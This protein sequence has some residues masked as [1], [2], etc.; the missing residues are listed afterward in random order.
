MSN[1]V[2]ALPV[3]KRDATAEERFMEL[4]QMAREDP[5]RF[6]KVIIGYLGVK[7]CK[8]GVSNYVTTGCNAL[9]AL[10]LA[11]LTLRNVEDWN[12]E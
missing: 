7:D 6:E 9:D 5:G 3:W 8:P 2:T 11:T 1:N 4:A 12:M 10:G